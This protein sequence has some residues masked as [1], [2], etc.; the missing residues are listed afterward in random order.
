MFSEEY[1]VGIVVGCDM[2]VKNKLL[3]LLGQG[4]GRAV[5]RQRTYAYNSNP[6]RL[7]TIFMVSR[8]TVMTRWKSSRG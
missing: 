3:P 8:L 1:L 2:D 7:L 6:G 4:G 5:V